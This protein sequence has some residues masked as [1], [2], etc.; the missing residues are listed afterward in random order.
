[1]IGRTAGLLVDLPVEVRPSGW[2]VADRAGRDLR[3]AAT[4]MSHD[5]DALTEHAHDY[6]GPLKIQV[7]GAW[8]L[9]ASIELRSVQRMGS[10]PGAVRDPAHTHGAGDR[11]AVEQ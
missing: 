11:A 1:M 3:R 2:R 5:L 4:L 9:T 6:N 10:D 8:T 7:A